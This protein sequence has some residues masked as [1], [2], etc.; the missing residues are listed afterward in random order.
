M[1]FFF[2]GWRF[3][4]LWVLGILSLVWVGCGQESVGVAPPLSERYGPFYTTDT[5][6]PPDTLKI[7]EGPFGDMVRYGREIVKY[8]PKYIGPN[9]SA[10]SYTRNMMSCQNCHLD[11]GTRNFGIN[12]LTTHARYPQYR[13]REGN[14]LSLE[15][16]VN[17]CVERP[18]S[19]DPLPLDSKEMI[20]ITSYIQW[21]GQGQKV[22]KRRNGDGYLAFKWTERASDPTRGA[23]LYVKHCQT[24]H[25][26]DG[27]GQMLP[28]SSQYKYPP[29]WGPYSYQP[30][31]SMHRVTKAAL[32]I[33]SNMPFDK[34]H[35]SKPTLT[36]QEC[37]DLAAFLN[38]D[39][40]HSRPA[41][42]NYEKSYPLPK[43]K[44]IGF[45]RGPYLDPFPEIQHKYGP[46]AP[47]IRWYEEQ[48]LDYS[49]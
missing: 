14:V 16:R 11:A 36:D 5:M 29:L 32:F 7:P 19:G 34:G 18:H 24:C 40:L 46:Y 33:K 9:G 28:D 39:S 13:S 6:V 22:G 42:P 4:F 44:P 49:L 37:L 47:I 8:T 43:Y 30:G 17:N 3:D 12:F 23:A 2:A 41:N 27:Q 1:V 45:D 25:Q 38:D 26:Q 35:W 31:S 48:G 15:Q 10:G 20:A 21:L